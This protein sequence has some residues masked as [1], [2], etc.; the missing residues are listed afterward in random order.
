MGPLFLNKLSKVSVKRQLCQLNRRQSTMTNNWNLLTASAF[1][2]CECVL[3]GRNWMGAVAFAV[4]IFDIAFLIVVFF[5]SISFNLLFPTNF[6]SFYHILFDSRARTFQPF[7]LAIC[8]SYIRDRMSEREIEVGG[9]E[10]ERA[11]NANRLIWPFW[12][13]F[14]LL[15]TT[16]FKRSK[17]AA[18][19]WIS[20][21]FLHGIHSSNACVWT[22]FRSIWTRW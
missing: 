1:F 10:R 17:P 20:R 6:Q 11:V 18:Y 15:T 3:V 19:D 21:C 13:Y 12:K 7:S 8:E 22:E 9:R 2:W 4:R 14:D 16:D 5:F